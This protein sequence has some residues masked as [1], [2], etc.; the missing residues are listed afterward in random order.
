MFVKIK[1]PPSLPTN[2][3]SFP[4]LDITTLE[5]QMSILSPR[6]CFLIKHY[7][8]LV[9]GP[10]WMR[11]YGIQVKLPDNIKTTTH[12]EFVPTQMCSLP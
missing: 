2:Q 11:Q 8:E 3:I 9:E 6:S 12:Y 4:P 5:E 7:E 1:I 10:K